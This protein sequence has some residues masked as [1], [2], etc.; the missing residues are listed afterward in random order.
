M[1]SFLKS[2]EIKLD[3]DEPTKNSKSIALTSKGKSA[4][5]LQFIYSEEETP[6]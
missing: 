5:T 2:H 4:K 3:G 1:I 6:G